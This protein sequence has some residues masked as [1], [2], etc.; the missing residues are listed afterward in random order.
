MR[1][2]YVDVICLI[3]QTGNIKPLYLIW[4]KAKKIP[5][6][7]IKEI[8]PKAFVDVGGSG[9]RYT[10]VFGPDIVRHLYL[11]RNK[12]YVEISEN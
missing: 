4:D 5:I 9:L 3:E 11:D 8:C 6:V 10:C 12:W 7:K 1:R 2:K